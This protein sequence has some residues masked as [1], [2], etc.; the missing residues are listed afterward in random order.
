MIKVKNKVLNF[1][2]IDAENP[3]R[4]SDTDQIKEFGL[5]YLRIHKPL[6]NEPWP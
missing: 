3:L 6:V 5:D 2:A 1:E 4:V